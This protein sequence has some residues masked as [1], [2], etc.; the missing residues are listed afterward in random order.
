MLFQSSYP[1]IDIPTHVPL[2]DFLFTP[3]PY[4][5]PINSPSSPPAFINALTNTSL[6]FLQVKE[7]SIYISTILVRNLGWVT[8]DVI[9]I[10][11]PNSIW[12]PVAL[13]GIL[14]A[15]C[16]PALSSPA[17]GE[18]EMVHA[19]K[20]VEAKHVI[21]YQ[22]NSNVVRAAARKC[23]IEEN[24]IFVLEGKAD[25]MTSV[26]DLVE[27]GRR[28]GEDSQV[29]QSSLPSG[30][31]NSEVCA[32]LCFSSGTTGLPKAV[33][34]SHQNIIAQ[35]LQLLPTTS[36]DHTTILGLL[37]FYH[38]T[39]V[40]KLLTLPLILPSSV[41]L[42]PHTP[43]S[44]PI[45]LSAISKYRI[46]EPQL[47]PPLVLRLAHSPLVAN[48]DLSC[49]KRFASGAALIS[50][51]VL[52]KLQERF[53]GRGFKQ[54]YGMTESTGCITTHPLWGHEFKYA[55]TGGTLV[56]NTSVKVVDEKGNMVGVGIKGEILA[57]GPQI[58]MGY[59]NNEKATRDAFDDEGFLRTGDE[60]SIDSEGFITIHDRIKEM[61]KVKGIQVAPVELEDL[62]LSYE[63]V[64]DCAVV[65]VKDEYSGERP[66]AFVALK[67]GVRSEGVER[68]IMRFVS[69]RKVRT[70]WLSGV[71]VVDVIPKSPSG[72]ILRRVL[73]DGLKIEER[74]VKIVASKL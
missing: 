65:G 44:L 14:R 66:F 18:D 12:Y 33:M 54:G 72:K 34:I 42:L 2:W 73:R 48:Y 53:P 30:M 20:T 36:K 38:I 13:F 58:V 31:K 26:Q 5:K 45:L 68:K 49:I 40:L 60:G 7:Y 22:E 37:P 55:R 4:F 41:I 15:G 8:G 28:L 43:L 69:E 19:F 35:L 71:K 9:S 24:R 74:S 32:V 61:I 25:G 29:E 16:I 62:L 56:A 39:G 67:E 46:A 27:E 21:C 11:T 6:S 51:P 57:K 10:C 63:K 70:K 50:L 17:F 1:D 47:V 59:F 52:K 64:E 23:G 3:S